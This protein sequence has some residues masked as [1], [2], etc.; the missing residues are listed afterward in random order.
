MK[1]LIALTDFSPAAENA[2]LYAA[3]LA[4]HVDAELLLLHV[5]QLPIT[6]NDMPVL[7]M[8]AEEMKNNAETGLGHVREEVLRQV[9][10]LVV[11]TESQMGD[12][13]DRVNQLCQDY[14]PFA[15]VMGTHHYSGLERVLF[16]RTPVSVVRH[17]HFPVITVPEEYKGASFRRLVLATDLQPVGEET[18]EKIRSLVQALGAELHLVHVAAEG[19]AED[20]APFLEPLR[21][22]NPQFHSVHGEDVTEGLRGYLE[23]VDAD[24]VLALPHRHSLMESLF[25]K[26][27][28]KDLVE[29]MDRPVVFVRE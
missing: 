12:L 26:G 21:G 22:L 20:A 6:M 3:R 9:P 10:G 14:H 8:T 23:R 4:R 13:S 19:S 2:T 7:M 24:V 1:T 29:A 17:C 15:V 11:R 5:Y 16:G 25:F 27:H 28:T 18:V